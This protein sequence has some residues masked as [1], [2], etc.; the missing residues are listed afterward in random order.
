MLFRATADLDGDGVEEPIF[1]L[2]LDDRR[3]AP[4]AELCRPRCEDV[5]LVGELRL[6]VARNWRRGA[7]MYAQRRLR[8]V[9]LD[10]RLSRR[11]IWIEERLPDDEDPGK[12][13]VFVSLVDGKLVPT[14][15]VADAYNAGA[16]EL[17]G[18]GRLQLRVSDCPNGTARY[19][20]TSD[21]TLRKLSV[22]T[23]RTPEGGCPG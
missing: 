22:H 12:E 23:G 19:E 6:P 4:D 8:V 9:Q 2:S 20:L 13:H 17:L 18:E 21:G 10:A 15:L 7:A 16:I 5:L 14:H 3:A 1:L 11:Q